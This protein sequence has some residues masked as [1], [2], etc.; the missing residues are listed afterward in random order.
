VPS[1]GQM[2]LICEQIEQRAAAS[3]RTAPALSS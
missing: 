3:V 2:T 1:I